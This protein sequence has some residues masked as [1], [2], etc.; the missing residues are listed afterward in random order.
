MRYASSAAIGYHAFY[1][2]DRCFA[3]ASLAAYAACYTY[4]F[5]AHFAA[6]VVVRFAVCSAVRLAAFSIARSSAARHAYVSE[7]RA[8]TSPAPIQETPTKNTQK[9]F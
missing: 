7:A 9:P 2:V 4:G 3:R 8:D 1:P 5:A 6:R